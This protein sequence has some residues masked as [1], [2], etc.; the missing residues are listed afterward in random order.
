[1]PV[2]A[3]FID[4]ADRLVYVRN[5][6]GEWD[7]HKVKVGSVMLAGLRSRKAL[8][9]GDIVSLIRPAVVRPSIVR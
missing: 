9:T 5:A 1:M 7:A 4:G 2:S 8:P 3:V 6:D